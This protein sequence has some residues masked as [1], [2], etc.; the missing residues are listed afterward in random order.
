MAELSLILRNFECLSLVC[1]FSVY[2]Y[3]GQLKLCWGKWEMPAAQTGWTSWLTAGCSLFLSPMVQLPPV[4]LR[5][6][7]PRLHTWILL[8]LPRLIS[9]QTKGVGLKEKAKQNKNRY[10]TMIH[11]DS[12]NLPIFVLQKGG[13][14]QPKEKEGRK[15]GVESRYKGRR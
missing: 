13:E 15:E 3:D 12:L 14:I 1:S 2:L 11:F 8:Y 6:H 5:P 4:H 9:P 7:L 10:R